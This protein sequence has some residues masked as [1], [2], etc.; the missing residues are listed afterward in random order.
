MSPVAET[1]AAYTAAAAPVADVSTGIAATDSVSIT[2]RLAGEVEAR[3][4]PSDSGESL[5][6]RFAWVYIFFREKLFRDDTERF[7]QA[8]WPKQ[9]P[10]AATRLIELGCGPGFYSC[11][12]ASRF[13]QISVLG[14]DRS[15]KQLD[16]ARNK[17]RGNVLQNCRF[18]R[19]NV[20]KLSHGDESFDA[21]VAARLFT[22][23]PN[24]ERAI[25]EMHRVLRPGGRCVIAEPRFAVWA[26]LPL[27]AMW[28]IAALTGMN[29]GYREPSRATVLSPEAFKGLFMTQPWRRV[30]TW[31]EGRYQYALCE[32]R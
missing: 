10:P 15:A 19:D 28:L 27:F 18:N 29:S 2:E 9:E 14:I 1:K 23:L 12:I 24:Q 13:P 17:A 30:Q 31:H 25:A 3:K 16:C 32:K 7:V 11:A 4:Q 21:L 5:F 20:L 26:S 6:E 22:V 8:L